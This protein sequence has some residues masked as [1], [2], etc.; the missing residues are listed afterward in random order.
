M[1]GNK[2]LHS[3]NLVYLLACAIEFC[4]LAIIALVPMVFLAI[5]DFPLELPKTVAFPKIIVFRT[6]VF[7][8]LVLWF[9]KCLLTSQPI[10]LLD[11]IKNIFPD[12]GSFLKNDLFRLIG[13]L[14]VLYFLSVTLSTLFSHNI[15]MSLWGHIPGSGGQS[16]YNLLNYGILFLIIGFNLRHRNQLLRLLATIIVIGVLVSGY[17]VLQYYDLGFLGVGSEQDGLDRVTSTMGNPVFLGSFLIFTIWVSIMTGLYISILCNSLKSYWINLVT[18]SLVLGL[19]IT[20]LIFTGSRGPILAILISF[21]AFSVLTIFGLGLKRALRSF[22]IPVL[23]L[24]VSIGLISVD[25]FIRSDA[26]DT[27]SNASNVGIGQR[28]YID[29]YSN[30]VVASS[31][32][33][34]IGIVKTSL[35]VILD[36]PM[37]INNMTGHTLISH[38]FGYGPESFQMAFMQRSGIRSDSKIPISTNHPHNFLLH[39]WIETGFFGFISI[40][41]LVFSIVIV[42]IYRLIRYR[43]SLTTLQLIFLIG[44]V[45]LILG[46]IV[47]QSF[48]VA[49]VPDLVLFWIT[50]GII[51]KYGILTDETSTKLSTSNRSVPYIAIVRKAIFS[52]PILWAIILFVTITFALVLWYKT[53][54]PVLAF[55]QSSDINNDFSNGNFVGVVESLQDS[56]ATDP[57]QYLYYSNLAYV[58][59]AAANSQINI[60]NI[61]CSDVEMNALDSNECF[62]E[63]AY[64]SY[65]SAIHAGDTRWE[66]RYKAA[67]V[68]TEISVLLQS[69]PRALDAIR[70]YDETVSMVPTAYLIKNEYAKSLMKFGNSSLARGVLLESLNITGNSVVSTEAMFL[71]G[72]SYAEIGDTDT[73]FSIW[74]D[75]LKLNKDYFLIHYHY[76][77]VSENNDKLQEAIRYQSQA[78]EIL[79]NEWLHHVASILPSDHKGLKKLSELESSLINFYEYRASLYNK[80][81]ANLRRDKDLDRALEIKSQPTFATGKK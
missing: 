47:E 54:I 16:L 58:Y 37:L 25:D 12:I 48:G 72:L 24:V 10:S 18:W 59:A 14:A 63:L 23:G 30:D 74:S 13:F 26:N 73:A 36:R 70:L 41:G 29:I 52:Q 45:S 34:R 68:A 51:C 1:F 20:A 7:L 38:V 27:Y 79:E 46:R 6:L 15:R 21:F 3:H 35:L 39:S 31:L 62:R 69:E 76:A 50:V 53:L 22:L 55:A 33:Q 75:A 4:W 49:Q 66:T 61:N 40:F 44:V 11:Q 57:S 64:R 9:L 81:G 56:L 77:L 32:L 2:S 60:E 5:P 65:L 71:L 17:A 78:I 19:Q 42:C 28:T 80:Q 8:M 67:K 43:N